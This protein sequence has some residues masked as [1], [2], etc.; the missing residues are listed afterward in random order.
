MC[1]WTR[2]QSA[3]NRRELGGRHVRT[4]LRTLALL[5]VWLSVSMPGYAS[6]RTKDDI[7]YMKNGDK[8][9]GEI[10]SLVQGQLSVKPDYASSSIVLDW[11]P[12]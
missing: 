2:S 3:G 8:I 12:S 7:V 10:Q 9:T 4:G 6:S 1:T 11:N 5:A